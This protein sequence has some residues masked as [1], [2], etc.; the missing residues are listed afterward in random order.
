VGPFKV[1]KKVGHSGYKL[2]LPTTWGRVHP[3]INESFLSKYHPPEAEHQH[4][5]APPPP[6]IID[7]TPEY[8]VEKVI[9]ERKKR[10]GVHYLVKWKGYETEHNTWEPKQN[11][12]NAQEAIKDYL[13]RQNPRNRARRIELDIT[14]A[15][16]FGPSAP[17]GGRQSAFIEEIPIENV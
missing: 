1:L 8:E 16:L 7:E 2:E 14:L 5:P 4:R 17:Q 13:K 12:K 15:E 10:G 6:D 9:G 3:V 11:L